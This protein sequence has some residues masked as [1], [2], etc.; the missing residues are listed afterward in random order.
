MSETMVDRVAKAL[1]MFDP[2]KGPYA[3]YEGM[4]RDAITAMR[5]PTE[6]MLRAVRDRDEEQRTSRHHPV[7]DDWRIMIDS[8][9]APAFKG[10]SNG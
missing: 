7:T 9:L 10:T 6:H 2:G 4:A 3:Y 1:Q 8:A 5:E